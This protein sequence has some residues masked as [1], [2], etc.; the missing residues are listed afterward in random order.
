MFAA[1]ASQKS[2]E[3]TND[4]RCSRIAFTD[5]EL[6]RALLQGVAHCFLTAALLR[7]RDLVPHQSAVY[8]QESFRDAL[9]RKNI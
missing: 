7:S 2:G 8:L 3:P 9:F 4:A 1:G 6:Q 5:L